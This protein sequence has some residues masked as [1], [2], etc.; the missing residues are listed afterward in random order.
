MKYDL[1]HAIRSLRPESAWS[2]RNNDYATLE[3]HCPQH[4][5]PTLQELETEVTRLQYEWDKQEYQRKR[6]A[7]YPP[8]VD[9]LDGIVKGD[10]AQIEA[11]INACI[12][13]KQKYPKPE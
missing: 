13:V 3:W 9:Y 12:A 2:M 6:A 1:T 8:M 10:T 7:E 4:S 11:Y 5:K